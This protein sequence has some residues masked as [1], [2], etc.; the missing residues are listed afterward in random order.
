[1]PWYFKNIDIAIVL[2]FLE[3]TFN[4]SDTMKV[5]LFLSPVKCVSTSICVRHSTGNSDK[6]RK[7]IALST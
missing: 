6:T 7:E 1:M 2:W 5:V 3:L 4:F